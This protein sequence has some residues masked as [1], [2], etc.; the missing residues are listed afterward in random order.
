MLDQVAS[1][2]PSQN[3]ECFRV[4]LERWMQLN[5]GVTWG[6]LELAITNANRQYLG[7]EPLKS[8]K[9]PEF[10]YIIYYTY[11]IIMTCINKK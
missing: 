9:G 7:Y 10:S 2:H 8:S 6:N 4:T 1:A 3:R 5:V 11:I